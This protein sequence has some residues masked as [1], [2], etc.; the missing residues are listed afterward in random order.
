MALSEHVLALRKLFHSKAWVRDNWGLQLDD[1]NGSCVSFNHDV[2]C[3][4]YAPVI[5][6]IFARTLQ[7]P[8]IYWL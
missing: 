2:F 7:M 1:Q 3:C 4:T 6:E 8:V 5:G